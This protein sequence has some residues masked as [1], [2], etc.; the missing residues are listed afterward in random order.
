[1]VYDLTDNMMNI[2]LYY[3]WKNFLARKLT[4]GITIAGIALVVFVFAAVLMM[5]DGIQ[6]T[7]S[8]TGSNDNVVIT[9]KSSSGEITSIIDRATAD[10]ISTMPMIQKDETGKPLLT[11]DAVTI[12]NAPKKDGGGLS[13]LAVR[14]VSENALKI[15]NKITIISGRMFTFGARE[16]IVGKAIEERFS[17]IAIGNTIKFAGDNWVIVGIMDAEKS[18]FE[19]ELWCD[20]N[21]LI[22]AFNRVDYSTLTFRI[23]D[24]ANIEQL[25]AIFAG[26]KRLNQYEP[27]NERKYFEKQSE[28]MRLF[29]Q[30]LGITITVIFSVGAMIGAMITMYAAVANRT[31]EIGTLRALG[32][33]RM[34]ILIAFLVESLITAFIGG[35]IGIGLASILQ[36]YSI[37]TLN[38]GSFSELSFSF[39]LTSNVI[40]G[41]LT[42]TGIMGFIGGFLP[43]VK[44]SRM[45]I[46][47]ALR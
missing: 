46:L 38:F 13:N 30:V 12:L 37:S 32:F 24:N 6:Q 35:F 40:Q 29:I 8:S 20:A 5:A 4:T 23:S 2:P 25:K 26:D 41:A 14:G 44:A 3:I 43:A 21:Q 1:M 28:A 18:A 33:Q 31:T 15:R 45:S 9:R 47:S 7:L 27:E 42:F 36:F 34:S 19:S 11:S 17:N 10:L 39:A 22:Q 16:L